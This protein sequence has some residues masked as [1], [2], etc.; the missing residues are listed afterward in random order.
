MC[1]ALSFHA[2]FC[3]M[4]VLFQD[5][6][7]ISCFHFLPP[8][9]LL[10]S[11]GPPSSFLSQL[12][13]IR[14]FFFSTNQQ[15]D[16][17]CYISSLLLGRWG[18]AHIYKWK[19]WGWAIELAIPKSC[20]HSALWWCIINNWKYRDTL[21]HNV[22]KGY[23]N[24]QTLLSFIT[25]IHQVGYN[26]L[27]FFLLQQSL[28]FHWWG[29]TPG[30][31]VDRWLKPWAALPLSMLSLSDIYNKLPPHSTVPSVASSPAATGFL[32]FWLFHCRLLINSNNNNNKT[33][34]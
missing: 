11:E 19:I 20:Q 14:S 27:I 24:I 25:C 23:H 6:Y 7:R 10:C 30:S 8:A 33:K 15:E 32:S 21:S 22:K 34:T 12:L 4:S 29:H 13:V 5:H 1:L 26:L 3:S 16:N 31:P 9:S 17:L 18:R 28:L 2:L